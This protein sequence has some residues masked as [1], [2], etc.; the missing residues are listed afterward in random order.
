MTER[1]ADTKLEKFVESEIEVLSP[2]MAKSNMLKAEADKVE[3]TDKETYISAKATRRELVTHRNSVRDMRL[4]FTRKLDQVKGLFIQKQDEVLAPAIE[5]EAGLKD[6]ISVWEE[7]QKR[8][9]EEE[10]AR[11]Q[12]ILD[13][14]TVPAMDRKTVTRDEVLRAQAALKMELGLLEQKDKNKKAVK[15]H[16]AGEREKINELLEF[17]DE[18][19]RQA[20]EAKALAEERAKLEE[21][22]A[23][24]E[25]DKARTESKMPQVGKDTDVP[26]KNED[27]PA[28]DDLPGDTNPDSMYQLIRDLGEGTMDAALKVLNDQLEGIRDTELSDEDYHNW[29][30]ETV[31]AIYQV[32][33]ENQ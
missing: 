13:K 31:D 14:L 4:T 12:S 19:D 28:E 25:H 17:V 26:T 24:L 27:A 5:A 32:I 33:A 18:R 8:L 6:K 3:I 7:E 22:R 21:D 20:A 9:K 23:N 15:D 11:I 16:V 10:E 30:L 29:K 1:T 2:L